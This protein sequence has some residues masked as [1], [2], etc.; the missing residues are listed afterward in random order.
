MIP[1]S[2]LQLYDE[3]GTIEH[4]K[5]LA[6]SRT[7]SSTGETEAL[8]YI[9]KELKETG[10]KSE[11]EHFNWMGPMGILMRTS[12]VLIFIYFILFS[13]FLLIIVYFLIKFMFAKTRR[14]SFIKKEESKNIFAHIPAKEKNPNRPLIIFSAHYDSISANIP[15]KLQVVIFFVYRLIVFLYALIIIVFSLIFFLYYFDIVPLTNFAGLLIT[16]TSIS[17]VFLSIPILYLVFGDSPSSG[18]ID[19][20]SGVA[21]SI[22]MAKFIK[23]NPF[24]NID[25]LFLWSGAEEFGL[26]GSKSFCDQHYNILKQKYDLDKS[27]NINLDMVGTYIGLLNKSGIFGKKINKN[28]NDLLESS[29]NQL[30]ISIRKHNRIISPKSDYKTFKK[31]ARKARSK[32]QVSCCYSSEDS[33]YIHSLRDTPDKCSTENLNG[34]LNICYHALKS[35]DSTN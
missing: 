19:N 5:A 12:Y 15:Y 9:E 4:V 34:C 30:E 1:I 17:G 24:E 8:Q 35:I 31:F 18:S 11:V 28:F 26:K 27:L 25:V 6:F 29:A 10:I 21:I 7:A 20:A 23:R 33:K 22:E 2:N 14:I 3:D 13:L 32:F 16:F